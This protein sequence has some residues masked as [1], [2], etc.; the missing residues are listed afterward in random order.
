MMLLFT[1]LRRMVVVIGGRIL[2]FVFSVQTFP[3]GV[4]I[5]LLLEVSNLVVVVTPTYAHLRGMFVP[6]VKSRVLS[7]I[8][9]ARRE[10]GS[11][12][13]MAEFCG[14]GIFADKGL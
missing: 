2:G 12:E 10:G 3:Y 5:R 7:L 11:C 9:A 1:A 13:G 8:A 14:F 4:L 6:I